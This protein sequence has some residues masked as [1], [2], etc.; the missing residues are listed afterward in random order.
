MTIYKPISE[1]AKE[2]VKL[3]IRIINQEKI[4]TGSTAYNGRVQVPTIL[5]SPVVVDST[6]LK[7]TVIKDKLHSYRDIYE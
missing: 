3:S 5:L 2:A 1:L 4:K 6:N 7:E